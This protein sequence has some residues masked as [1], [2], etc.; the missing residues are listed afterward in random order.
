MPIITRASNA[1]AHPGLILLD[2]QPTKRTKQQIKD[3]NARKKAAAIAAEDK[4][5]GVLVRLAKSE[6]DVDLEEED[7]RANSTRPDIR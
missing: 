6:A 5:C 1:L 2:G 4:R 7:I 3:D